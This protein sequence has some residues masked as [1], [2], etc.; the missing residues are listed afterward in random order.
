RGSVLVTF[1]VM[2]AVL[3]AVGALATDVGVAYW[4][5]RMVQDG[6]DAA[7]LA[8]AASLP[9][10]PTAAVATAQAVA[11]ENGVTS[12]ELSVVSSN[13]QVTTIFNTNGTIVV[14]AKRLDNWGLRYVDGGGNINI[15]AGSTAIVVAMSPS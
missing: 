5:R 10:L 13:P 12:A 3:L 7:A 8:G 9:A 2:M 15:G 6:T 1:T 11:G 14:S 4:N